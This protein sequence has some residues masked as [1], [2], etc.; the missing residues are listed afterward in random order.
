MATQTVDVMHALQVL[1]PDI[2]QIHQYDWS[3]GHKKNKV[4]GLEISSMHFTLGG[5]GGK[6]VR[7]TELSDDLVDDNDVVAMI[8]ESI[9]EGSTSVWSLTNPIAN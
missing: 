1:E 4:G 3:S 7:D 5:N 9:A 2:Q 8:Y 6:E